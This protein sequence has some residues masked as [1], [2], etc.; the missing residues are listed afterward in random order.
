MR[1]PSLPGRRD[2]GRGGK[3]TQESGVGRGGA[4]GGATQERDGAGGRVSWGWGVEGSIPWSGKGQ[5][6]HTNMSS[7][8]GHPVTLL[9][10]VGKDMTACDSRHCCLG[11]MFGQ[12]LVLLKRRS[13]L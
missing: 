8:I 10:V 9:L 11:V 4:G 13:E 7:W 2:G 12:S 6:V 1:S 5:G 3:A